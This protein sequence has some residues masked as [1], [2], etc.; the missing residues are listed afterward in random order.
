MTCANQRVDGLYF[1]KKNDGWSV[2]VL[3]IVG[4]WVCA[5]ECE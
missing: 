4:V 2:L 1:A 5:S 3:R